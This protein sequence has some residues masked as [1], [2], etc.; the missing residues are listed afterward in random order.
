MKDEII[1]KNLAECGY[2]AAR[3]GSLLAEALH[4]AR[5]KLPFASYSLASARVEPGCRTLPHTLKNSSE[6]YVILEGTGTL[7]ACG[8]YVALRPGVCVCVPRGE[9]QY[10]VNDGD[11]RLDFLCVVSPPWNEGDE[12]ILSGGES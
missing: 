10:V 1:V 7:R 3:D 4:P 2:F 12:E 11:K 6:T 5:E 9:A 8:K